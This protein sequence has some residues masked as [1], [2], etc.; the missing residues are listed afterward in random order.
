MLLRLECSHEFCH[1]CLQQQLSA[2]WPSPRVVFGYLNCALCR[3]PLGHKDLEESLAPHQDLRQHVIDVAARKFREDKLDDDLVRALG[4]AVTDEEV[5]IRAEAAMAVF[6]CNDCSEPYCGGRADCAAFLDETANKLE[7]RCDQCE[8]AAFAAA[9]DRR[10]M[11]HGH[12]YAIYKC[13]SCCAVAVWCCDGHHY[14]ERCHNDPCRDK[15]FPCLGPGRCPLGIPHPRNTHGN[16]DKAMEG[17]SFVIGCSACLGFGDIEQDDLGGPDGYEFGF[18]DR[19]WRGFLG[20]RDLLA[21]L[22]E[23]EVRER[24]RAL[25]PSLPH[26][27][28]VLECAERLLIREQGVRSPE[29]VLQMGGNILALKGRLEAVGLSSDGPPLECAQRLLFLSYDVPLESLKLWD[30]REALRPP[31][32]AHRKRRKI[33]VRKALP[34]RGEVSPQQSP[35]ELVQAARPVLLSPQGASIIVPVAIG[36]AMLL[37]LSLI[38]APSLVNHG[39]A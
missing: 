37:A 7:R 19:D 8:W 39:F 30:A 36:I 6:M 20:G 29:E 38:C 18:P 31:Q 1:G 14:C 4:R 9:D 32:D 17:P 27:G 23:E 34:L 10:C 5:R 12:R 15:D 3:S 13:D 35:S 26:D 2:R 33:R 24:L 11:V 21:A 25:R 22:G 16:L 28:S